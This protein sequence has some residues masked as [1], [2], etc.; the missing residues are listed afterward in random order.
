MLYT[1]FNNKVLIFWEKNSLYVSYKLLL[2]LEMG[3][4]HLQDQL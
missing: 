1:P 4:I 2:E 3:P